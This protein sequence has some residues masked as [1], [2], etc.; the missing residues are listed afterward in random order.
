[1]KIL[2]ILLKKISICSLIILH[3]IIIIIEKYKSLYQ[4][5]NA[6][7]GKRVTLTIGMDGKIISMDGKINYRDRKIVKC[8]CEKMFKY[9]QKEMCK[10]KVTSEI[11]SIKYELFQINE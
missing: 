1:M 4:N 10:Q 7:P 8:I 9:I 3:I 2:K 11:S 6:L 5:K